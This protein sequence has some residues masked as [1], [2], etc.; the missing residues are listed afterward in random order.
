[1]RTLFLFGAVFLYD[2]P[3]CW[4]IHHLPTKGDTGLDRAQ[5][6]LAARADGDPMLNHFIGLLAEAQGASWVSL[7][8]AA[9]LPALFAQ[10]FSLASKAIGGGGQVTIAAVFCQPI[11]QVFDLLAQGRNLFLHLLHLL[12]LL[13]KPTFLLLNDGIT[14][15]QLLTQALIFFFKAHACTLLALMTFGKSQANLGSYI[16]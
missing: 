3:G 10:A 13:A 15:G 16:N 5:I 4:D 2:Q 6:V 11:L 8:P 7:L 12:I 14:L 9:F 1:V